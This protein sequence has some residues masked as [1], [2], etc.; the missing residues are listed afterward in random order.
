MNI[1]ELLK[2]IDNEIIE[3]KIILGERASEYNSTDNVFR[4]FDN[5]ANLEKRTIQDVIRTQIN[6][7]ISR[8]NND[9]KLDTILDL[10]NFALLLKIY[11]KKG[12]EI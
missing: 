9:Y 1:K 8:L 7:K 12:K 4:V 3:Q 5:V 10:I 11:L 2:E 6:L